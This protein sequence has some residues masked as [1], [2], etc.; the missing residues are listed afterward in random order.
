MPA[1]QDLQRKIKSA[2]DLHMVVRTMKALAAVSIRQYE[3]AVRA[4]DG[5]HEAVE[6]G[7]RALLRHQPLAGH[8]REAEQTVALVLGSDQGMAGRFNDAVL[9][10]VVE[11]LRRDGSER[12]KCRFWVA[13]EKAAG[14]VEELFG[15][16]EERFF[17]PTSARNITAV[18]QEVLVRFEHC[19]GGNACRLL[20][21]HNAPDSKASYQ[22]RC[23][24]LLP[25]DEDWLRRM[26]G[27][28]WPGRC[29][30]YHSASRE[31]LFAALIGEYLF[32]SLFRG[33]ASSLAAEHA[34]RLAAMQRAEKNIEELQDDLKARY[35]T[36]RQ[37]VITEELFDII[38]G[39]E[40][41]NLPAGRG[42][43]H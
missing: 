37:N 13:G 34:A 19:R 31:A 17:L 33:F 43:R 6:L 30:P 15:R 40:A 1:L 36:L 28:R 18:V 8:G 26:A 16:A 12:E 7:L 4:T 5:Y 27:R 35:H 24:M 25:P 20:L 10:S 22:Q 29:L 23:I 21:F 38:S 11:R 3:E 14:G 41:L 42:G 32:V 2:A 39:F 9:E